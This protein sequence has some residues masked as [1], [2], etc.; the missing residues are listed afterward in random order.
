[1]VGVDGVTD[2]QP[3]IAFAFDQASSRGTGLTVVHAW[4]NEQPAFVRPI[5]KRIVARHEVTRE[6]ELLLSE[7]LAGWCEKY[8]DVPV[9]TSI[10]YSRPIAALLEHA[11]GSELLVVG[12]RGRGGFSGLVLGSVSHAV[13]QHAASPVAVVRGDR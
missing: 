4:E 12:S 8:S 3:A 7:T 5:A 1:V 10:V 2:S 13:L 9:R 6:R 11:D